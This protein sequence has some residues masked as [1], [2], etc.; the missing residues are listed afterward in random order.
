MFSSRETSK[1]EEEMN[2][3]E[4]THTLSTYVFF[5]SIEIEMF[6]ELFQEGNKSDTLLIDALKFLKTSSMFDIFC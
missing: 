5:Y 3:M 1:Q 2:E 6:Q 4:E